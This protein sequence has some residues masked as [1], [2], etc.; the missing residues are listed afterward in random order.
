MR[1]AG[2]VRHREEIINSNKILVETP[3]DKIS[4]ER[5]V[6]KLKDN[7]KMYLKETASKAVNCFMMGLLR[8]W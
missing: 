8:T 5:S 6:R 2:H 1:W 7:I 4:L 3:D